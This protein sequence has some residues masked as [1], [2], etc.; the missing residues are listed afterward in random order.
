MKALISPQFITPD[1]AL[2]LFTARALS[3]G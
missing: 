1:Y 2:T 3:T